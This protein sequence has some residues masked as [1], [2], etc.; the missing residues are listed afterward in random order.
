MYCSQCGFQMG[1]ECRF[2][3]QCGQ[4]QAA[5]TFTA[6]EVRLSSRLSRSMSEKKVAGV[7]AGIARYLK[8]DVT[9]V[10]ILMLVLAF[11]P[12]VVGLL[13][14][15]ACWIVM[16]RDS[17]LPFRRTMGCSRSR[18]ADREAGLPYTV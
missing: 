16:P 3:S 13:L 11:Y 6:Q 2:C 8:I 17:S 14:Y 10:R 9:L 1:S 7:C 18:K 4:P 12:P 15:V 5:G